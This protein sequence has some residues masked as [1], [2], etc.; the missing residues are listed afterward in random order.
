MKRFLLH[1]FAWCLF[2]MA[3]VNILADTYRY[4]MG[5]FS[6]LRGLSI[7]ILTGLWLTIWSFCREKSQK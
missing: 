4:C 6:L 7:T 2:V 5:D 1:W 3:T